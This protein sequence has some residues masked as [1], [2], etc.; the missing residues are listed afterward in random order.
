METESDPELPL[1]QYASCLLMV[2]AFV[3][4]ARE[5]SLVGKKF[6]MGDVSPR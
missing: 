3:L 1:A 5:I 2:A 4:H 6:V